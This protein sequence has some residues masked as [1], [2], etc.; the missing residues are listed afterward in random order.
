MVVCCVV[1]CCVSGLPDR[2]SVSEA[3]CIFDGCVVAAEWPGLLVLPE[4][5]IDHRTNLMLI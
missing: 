4:L 2:G 5:F 1:V 3:A